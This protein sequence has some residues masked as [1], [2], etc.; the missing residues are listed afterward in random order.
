LTKKQFQ[1]RLSFFVQVLNYPFLFS[2]ILV[3][4]E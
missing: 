1:S 3:I 4:F 2:F